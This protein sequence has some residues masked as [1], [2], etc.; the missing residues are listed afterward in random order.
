MNVRVL[1][2]AMA[3]LVVV[4]CTSPSP[5]LQAT[6]TDISDVAYTNDPTD[7]ANCGNTEILLLT[8]TDRGKQIAAERV[9]GYPFYNSA[10]AFKDRRGHIYV[11]RV[12]ES[13]EGTGLQPQ[14]IHVERLDLGRGALYDVVKL[15]WSIPDP[16]GSPWDTT[17]Q[18]SD[19]DTEDGGL[20]VTLTYALP[21]DTQCCMLSEKQITVR[22][23]SFAAS[24]STPAQ[25]APDAVIRPA[26][27]EKWCNGQDQG[28]MVTLAVIDKD[29]ALAHKDECR[30]PG[31]TLSAQAAADRRGRIYM[32]LRTT[33]HT[34][35]YASDTLSIYELV[36]SE[37][38]STSKPDSYGL[39]WLGDM[40]LSPAED[41]AA[42]WPTTYHVR[43]TDG[44][45]LEVIA[46]YSAIKGAGCCT[47]PERQVSIQIG[48]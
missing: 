16:D 14:E 22:L 42:Q 30:Y 3:G 43:D 34:N 47:P 44:G 20:N 17:Y 8:V 45:G 10:K 26:S 9:C 15:P 7:R 40:L 48:P 1:L 29:H 39:E 13:S 18:V 32:L 21:P 33:W 6:I 27:P 23:G 2:A 46:D 36:G 37:F 25:A 41:P 38:P 31:E 35:G 28:E 24:G 12:T 4:A 19:I 11:L 5:Q